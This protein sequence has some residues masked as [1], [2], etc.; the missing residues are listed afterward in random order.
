MSKVY[1]SVFQEGHHVDITGCHKTLEGAQHH[2]VP[3]LEE[4][5]DGSPPAAP[6]RWN[7]T[8]PGEWVLTVDE[9]YD[10]WWTITETSVDE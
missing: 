10:Y 4:I 8:T 2:V 7:S 6:V 3:Q 9:D 5:L 1:I